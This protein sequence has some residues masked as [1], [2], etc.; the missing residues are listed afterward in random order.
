MQQGSG[1]NF[2]KSSNFIISL[3]LLWN[4][5]LKISVSYFN[6]VSFYSLLKVQSCP[7][8]PILHIFFHFRGLLITDNLCCQSPRPR[9]L[10]FQK[11]LE[12]KEVEPHS[13]FNHWKINSKDVLL[14]DFVF[15]SQ[16]QVSFK[17]Q[18]STADVSSFPLLKYLI[19]VC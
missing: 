11:Q 7:E 19:I 6:S 5:F 3:L 10:Q 18:Q 1:I 17:Q 9:I 12:L 14:A 4:Y 16:V 15:L 13:T 8:S 2:L